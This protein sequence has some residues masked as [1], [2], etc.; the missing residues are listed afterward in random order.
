MEGLDNWNLVLTGPLSHLTSQSLIVLT[1]NR[2][3]PIPMLSHK[4]ENSQIK[5]LGK[6]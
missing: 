6:L 4:L 1:C 3:V 5:S 2:E